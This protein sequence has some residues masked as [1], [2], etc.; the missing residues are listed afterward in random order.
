M[1]IYLLAI[2]N[3]AQAEEMINE[4]RNAFKSNLQNLTWMDTETQEAAKSKADAIT[5]MIGECL[6]GL[7]SK[8][9]TLILVFV[10]ESKNVCTSLYW[11]RWVSLLPFTITHFC[12]WIYHCF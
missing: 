4:V 5:D 8:V 9:A 3:F 6:H 12:Q 11:F 2:T 10:V 1:V 7:S